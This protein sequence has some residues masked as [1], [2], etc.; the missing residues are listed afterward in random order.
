LGIIYFMTKTFY[1]TGQNNFGNRGCEALVRSTLTVLTA[2]FG[3]VKILVPSLDPLRDRAQ[4]PDG[5]DEG[6]EFVSTHPIPKLFGKWMG[7]SQRFKW[8][9]NL[10]APKPSLPAALLNDLKRSDVLLSIGGD[11]YSLD[12]GL[13]SLFYFS[14]IAD[15][16]MAMGKPAVLW[17]ASV[18]PFTREPQAEQRMV[19]HLNRLNLI[20]VR[21][22]RSIEYL[23]GIGVHQNVLPVIDSA[24]AMKPQPLNTDAWWPKQTGGGVLALNIGWLID[25]LRRRAGQSDGV[26]GEV[27]AFVRDVLART[28]LA[29]LLVPHVAPLSGQAENND[30]HLNQR[31]LQALGGVNPRLSQVPSG[32]NAAQLKYIISQSRLLIAARTHATIAAFST[33]VP[34]L[35]IAYSVKAKGINRDLF[36]HERY[37]LETPKLSQSTLWDGLQLLLKEEAEIRSHY[38]THLPDWR[39]RAHAGAYRLAEMLNDGQQGGTGRTGPA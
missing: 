9:Q 35:S 3:R 33:G 27:V 36:G 12:Y 25:S 7:A 10:P 8:L 26:I 23:R 17:G 13:A 37:V 38:Q 21:E 24:F 2:A 28:D 19:A 30:D 14:G 15:A 11:N 20:S 6:V 32:L 4:W 22:S 39:E 18:G 31:L 1:L 16:A 5:V 34:T 29:V